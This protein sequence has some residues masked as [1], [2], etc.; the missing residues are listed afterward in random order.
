MTWQVHI[1]ESVV[2]A[3]NQRLHGSGMITAAAAPDTKQLLVV[4][5]IPLHVESTTIPETA[6][7]LKQA[8]WR[9]MMPE[10]PDSRR[11]AEA[12]DILAGAVQIQQLLPYGIHALG[13]YSSGS[14][15]I[16]VA[17]VDSEK[18]GLLPSLTAC[19]STSG[20]VQWE[21][22]GQPVSPEVV[23]SSATSSL[24]L[25]GFTAVR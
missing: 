25:P 18:S 12:T 8:R 4:G 5:L 9:P 10:K 2:N 21:L 13:V 7:K 19:S 14:S 20:K 24:S 23:T 6:G 11:L 3:V 16:K 15:S 22:D 17:A 1:L